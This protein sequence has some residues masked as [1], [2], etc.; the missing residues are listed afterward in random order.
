MLYISHT[1][2]DDNIAIVFAKG[3]LH[4]ATSNE[5]E[6]YISNI[7]DS[8]MQSVIF[9]AAS[10]DYISS[11]GIGA[12][13]YVNRKLISSKGKFILCNVPENIINVLRIIKLDNVLHITDSQEDAVETAQ[14]ETPTAGTE[15]IAAEEDM[16]FEEEPESEET[17]EELL[18]VAD[19]DLL[20]EEIESETTAP[21]E[22]SPGTESSFTHPLIVECAECK[23]LVRVTYPGTFLCPDCNTQFTVEEDRTIIF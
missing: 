8:G 18:A 12:L 9:D 13:L 16:L 15:E 19:E 22:T 14:Q 6:S 5:F 7:V 1:H 23:S 4:N 17:I 11:T 2:A 10:V 21:V 20:A 3:P